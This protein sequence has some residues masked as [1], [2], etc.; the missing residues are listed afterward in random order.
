MRNLFD[1]QGR[2]RV[3]ARGVLEVRRGR[4]PAENAAN[5]ENS[6][7]WVETNEYHKPSVELVV[8]DLLLIVEKCFLNLTPAPI[9]RSSPQSSQR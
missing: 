7:L 1:E 8:I 3:F 5:R 2:T 6:H 4:K 9:G